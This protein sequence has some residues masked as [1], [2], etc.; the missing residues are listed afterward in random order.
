MTTAVPHDNTPNSDPHSHRG[1]NGL[2]VWFCINLTCFVWSFLLLIEILWTVEPLDRLQGTHVYLTWNF[3]TTI[4]WVVETALPVCTLGWKSSFFQMGEW[5][6]ALYF[7]VDSIALF[8]QWQQPDEDI[9]GEVLDAVISLA[10]Y[11]YL[12]WKTA[13]WKGRISAMDRQRDEEKGDGIAD[14]EEKATQYH[15]I[16]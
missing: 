8:Q 2:L 9:R 16:S 1:S 14:E 5:I 3:G 4:I 15:E 13:G 12:L 6:L 10:A 11:A 7:L